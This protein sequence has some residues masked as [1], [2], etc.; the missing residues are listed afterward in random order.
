MATTARN[1]RL[2]PSYKQHGV[3]D[4]LSGVVLDVE[5]TTGEVNEGHRRRDQPQAAC[6]RTS[7]LDPY[8]LVA[9]DAHTAGLGSRK[10]G[11]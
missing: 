7:C 2:E 8:V 9:S 5:V 10:P 4:D 1:R 3:V 6:G 11:T